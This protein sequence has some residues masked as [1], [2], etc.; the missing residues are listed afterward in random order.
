MRRDSFDTTGIK[1][2]KK[3]NYIQFVETNNLEILGEQTLKFQPN[4]ILEQVVL[5]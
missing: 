1:Y 5:C 2:L 4:S 3:F